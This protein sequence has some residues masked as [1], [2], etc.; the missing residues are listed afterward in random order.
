MHNSFPFV[1]SPRSVIVGALGMVAALV[2]A[3]ILARSYPVVDWLA[4]PVLTLWSW[5]VV[6]AAS[7]VCFG[8]F[9]LTSILQRRTNTALETIALAAPIGVVAFTMGMYVAGFLG[10]YGPVFAV[11]LP[12]AMLCAGLPAAARR[13]RTF[14]EDGDPSSA[15]GSLPARV[16]TGFGVVMLGLIYLGVFSPESLNYDAVWQHVVSAQDYAREGRIVPFPGDWVRGVPN[17]ASLMFTWGYLVPGLPVPALKWMMAL[18]IEFTLFVGT[19]VGLGALVNRLAERSVRGGWVAMFVF[20]SVFVYDSNLGGAA[21]HVAAFFAAPLFLVALRTERTRE[22]RDW[23][24]LAIISAGALLTKYQS[25]CMIAPAA[26]IPA[27]AVAREV[28]RRARHQGEFRDGIRNLLLGPAVALGCLLVLTAPHFVKNYVFHGNPFYPFAQSLLHGHPGYPAADIVAN[29]TMSNWG[30][31]PP[32]AFGPRLSN[33][34]RLLVDF[35]YYPHGTWY[36]GN[37]PIVGSLFTFL[38]PVIPFLRRP[39]TLLVGAF[40][41]LAMVFLWS[42]T[43]VVD[44][45]LQVF[46]PILAAVV[47]ATLARA[48]RLGWIARAGISAL[49]ACQVIAGGDLVFSG[50]DRLANAATLI[51]SGIDGRAATRFASYRRSFLDLGEALPKNALVV[52]HNSHASLGIDRRLLLDWGGYQGLFDPHTYRTP[53]DLYSRWKALG[54]THVVVQ[55][56]NHPTS[57]KQEEVVFAAFLDRFAGPTRRIGEFELMEVP[58]NPPPVEAPYEV[59]MLGIPNYPDGLYKVEELS[60][61]EDMP[62]EYRRVPSALETIRSDNELTS[63]LSHARA[64]LIGSGYGSTPAMATILSRDFNR[65]VSFPGFAVYLRR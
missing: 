55:R 54:V 44:R 36:V 52:L 17:L 57:T 40:G 12:V 61:W 18:H 6:L 51:H 27:V 59:V 56:G 64:A 53:R 25:V 45:N 9:V 42:W 4:W 26:A 34:L 8:H 21:D 41:G 58:I 5:Q 3:P 31:K 22:I 49:V 30:L 32:R 1:R 47:G 10:L 60:V 28:F 14:M 29:E 48:V 7:C 62:P 33:S 50:F 65:S 38:L 20:P 39:R 13:V 37:R 16:V 46:L 24:L 11:V 23:F 19:L 15:P 35:S 2:L 43:Y 63:P